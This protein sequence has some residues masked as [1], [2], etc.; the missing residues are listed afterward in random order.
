MVPTKISSL[1][2]NNN[3]AGILK[4][5]AVHPTQKDFR[6]YHAAGLLNALSAGSDVI[7]VWAEIM[8]I[9]L[10]QASQSF[11]SPAFIACYA[12]LHANFEFQN[13]L[14]GWALAARTTGAPDNSS[15]KTSMIAKTGAATDNRLSHWLFIAILHSE[16]ISFYGNSRCLN[17]PT[18]RRHL[19]G[20]LTEAPASVIVSLLRDYWF[21]TATGFH[22][23]AKN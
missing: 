7:A 16:N 12:C 18:G 10:V 9:K 2:S 21:T 19:A 8:S 3:L 5:S 4:L 1:G 22:S 15:D 6:Y 11:I 17:A 14:L 23:S 20:A 13:T